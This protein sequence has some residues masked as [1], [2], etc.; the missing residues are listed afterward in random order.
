MVKLLVKQDNYG[1]KIFIK[2][3]FKHHRCTGKL[4]EVFEY[5][6]VALITIA[7]ECENK[8]HINIE[9]SKRRIK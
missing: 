8:K 4:S 7:T 3:G 1:C 9:V 6:S 5:L 2:K